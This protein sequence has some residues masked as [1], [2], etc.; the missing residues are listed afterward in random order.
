MKS[1]IAIL[2]SILCLQVSAQNQEDIFRYS[3]QNIVGS[4][5]T[6]GLSGA[7][8]AAGAD[9]SAAS[10]NPAGLGLYRKNEIMGSMA[11]TSTLSKTDYNGNLMN[12]GRTMFNIPNLGIVFSMVNQNMGKA[13]RNGIVGGSFAFG[14]NRL[15]DFQTSTQYSG[16]GKNTTVGDYLARSASG[17]DSAGFWNSNYDNTLSALAWRVSLIDNNGARNQYASIL[18]RQGDTNYTMNQFQQ[19]NTKGRMNEWYAGGGLNVANFLYLGATM[20]IQNAKFESNN[21]YKENISTS[22][23]SNNVYVGST[24]NQNLTSSGTGVGGKFGLILRPIDLIR[25]GVSYHTPV[26]LNMTDYYQNSISM[27]FNGTIYNQPGETREDYYEYQIITPQRLMASGS[28]VVG[29]LLII[30]ADYERVDYTKGRLQA[31]DGQTDFA[32]ANNANRQVYGIGQNYRAGVEFCGKYTRLRAGYALIGSAY[33]EQY[34]SKENGLKQ[35][36]SAGFGWV[37][38]NAY[39]FDLAVSS[40]IGNDYITPYEGNPT[41]AINSTNKLNFLF[42]A[43]YR[44]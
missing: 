35:L 13:K 9:L 37:Y 14:M 29:K 23:V 40:R 26:R 39:F 3:N 41:S 22:S 1:K 27:N 42:G 38:N 44:F 36:I 10:F 25:V 16:K 6:L 43:G 18:E 34:V 20:V 12:D 15:N 2:A 7:W 5:R 21:T 31:K 32:T 4:A 24:I 33:K 28:I 8:G 11:I 17:Y 30:N 19:I